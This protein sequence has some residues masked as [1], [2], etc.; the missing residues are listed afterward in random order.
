MNLMFIEIA[1]SALIGTYFGI[2]AHATGWG[3][4]I[5]FWILQLLIW[6]FI[7]LLIGI[8]KLQ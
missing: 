3:L 6:L 8:V 5:K 7:I 4:N 1:I 2:M